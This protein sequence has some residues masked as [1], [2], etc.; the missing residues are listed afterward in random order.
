MAINRNVTITGLDEVLRNLRAYGEA[1]QKAAATAIFEEARAIEEV[2]VT[3]FAPVDLGGL[4][5]DMAFVD[6]SATISG[7]KASIEFGY[8]G[9]YAASV[10]EN[11][12]TGRTGG[13]P[14]DPHD[15]PLFRWVTKGGNTWLAPIGGQRR[16]WATTGG[17]KFL[18]KPLLQAEP[19]MLGRLANRIRNI[20]GGRLSSELYGG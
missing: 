5:R 6:E 12:R 11:P 16:H 10:H 13:W 7:D 3:Q 17:W 14:P 1:T 19:G 20:V 18:E 9:P 8:R 2:S 4:T 15:P